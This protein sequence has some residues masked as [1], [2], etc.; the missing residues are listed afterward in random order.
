M[1]LNKSITSSFNSVV[2]TVV[3]MLLFPRIVFS[4]D[5][6]VMR[7]ETTIEIKKGTLITKHLWEVKINNKS[8]E[9]FTMISL[10]YSG[11]V[12]VGNIEA[13]IRDREGKIVRKLDRGSIT[14][15]SDISNISLY[16][17]SYVKEFTLRHN[18]YPYTLI[19]SYE[20]QENQFIRIDTWVPVLSIDV[21]THKAELKFTVPDGYKVRFSSPT[22]EPE[23]LNDPGKSVSYK[24]ETTYLKTVSKPEVFAPPLIL[25]L[26]MVEIVPVDF[27]FETEGSLESWITFGNWQA[28]LIG[29]PEVLPESEQAR[30]R[31]LIDGLTEKKDILKILYNYLQDNTRYINVS[32]ETGGLKPHP[33]SYVVTN[34]YGDCKAL[35]NYFRSVLHYAGIRSYYSKI[36]AGDGSHEIDKSFPSQ[37]FNH[38]ILCVPVDGDTTWVDCTSDN[39][40]GYVGT[41]IQ[42]RDVLVIDRDR[43]H[44]SRTPALG[45]SDVEEV[46][47]AEITSPVPPLSNFKMKTTVRGEKYELLRFIVKE[48]PEKDRFAVIVNEFVPGTLTVNELSSDIVNRD[49]TFGFL[50]ITAES[51]RYYSVYGENLVIKLLPFELPELK[52]PDI[53]VNPLL[54]EYPIALTDTLFYNIPTGYTVTTVPKDITIDIPAGHFSSSYLT[55]DRGVGVIKKVVLHAGT[56][57]GDEYNEVYS[58]IKKIKVA[59]EAPIIATKKTVL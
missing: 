28:D 15:R 40:L 57:K 8:G 9:K 59:E 18:T 25:S 39:P 19:Y 36:Y 11:L 13:M 38:I 35:S 49:S 56:Y 52:G 37:S 20:E 10:P 23:V 41:F 22:I 26:P 30:I 3:I 34:K 48:V 5:A 21:P 43:S 12:Q 50:M 24:W 7:Q 51:N 44:F 17:D 4:Q 46:R 47:V 1:G 55:S 58:F 32:I 16:E 53:R 31:S 45:Y 33:V 27:F 29:P 14:D 42:N 2:L 54:I 6:E